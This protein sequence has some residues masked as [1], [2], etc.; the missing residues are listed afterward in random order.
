LFLIDALSSFNIR[1]KQL[2]LF[3]ISIIPYGSCDTTIQLVKFA[4]HAIPGTSILNSQLLRNN[5]HRRLGWLEKKNGADLENIVEAIC[6]REKELRPVD[7]AKDVVKNLSFDWSPPKRHW[8]AYVRK[9]ES[10]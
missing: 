2:R 5:T 8:I 9:A 10:F 4:D 3:A 6:E 1:L 7:F